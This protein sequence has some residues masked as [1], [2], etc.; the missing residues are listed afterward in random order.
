MLLTISLTSTTMTGTIMLTSNVATQ[1]NVSQKTALGYLTMYNVTYDSGDGTKNSAIYTYNIT[2][3]NV[4]KDSVN[5]YELKLSIGV[6]TPKRKT[7]ARIVG[8][9]TVMI[10]G[11]EQWR[12]LS[13]LR[14]VHKYETETN[15]PIVVTVNTE[16]YYRNYIGYPGWPYKVGQNWT[17]E[18]YYV[19]S[20]SLVSS[21][22]DEWLARVVSNSSIVTVGNVN[23]TCYQVVHTITSTGTSTPPGKGVGGTIT[24]YWITNGTL[25]VPVKIVDQANFVGQENRTIMY[26]PLNLA[27]TDGL[28]VNGHVTVG[29][30]INYTISFSNA[31]NIYKIHN[32]TITDNLPP[33]NQTTFISASNGGICQA[34]IVV[35]KVGNV[36]AGSGPYSV[37]VLVRVQ[38]VSS[39]ITIINKATIASNETL[40]TTA[41]ACT[42]CVPPS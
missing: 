16:V 33:A 4:T 12:S 15:V 25:P 22:A 8:T 18:A 35:W 30:T 7:H 42:K 37:W 32:V 40:P 14:L 19:P 10:A 26:N 3:T 24:D 13:D 2:Q 29:G 1:I 20:S 9:A 41:W 36:T 6:G 5:C 17:Y 31:K 28:A 34:G 23:Y 39:E 11:E 38:Y 27:K 21:W